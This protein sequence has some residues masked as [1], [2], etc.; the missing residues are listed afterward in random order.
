VKSLES[1]CCVVPGVSG[2]AI[3]GNG[4][5]GLLLDT[6]SLAAAV[7]VAADRRL[8]TPIG[9][10]SGPQGSRAWHE[11]GAGGGS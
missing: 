8:S 2:A 1:N 5:I 4:E 6:S 7:R 3:L 10:G 9:G 11:L